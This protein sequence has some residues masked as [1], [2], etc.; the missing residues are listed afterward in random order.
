MDSNQNEVNS[1]NDD[2]SNSNLKKPKNNIV[3]KKSLDFSNALSVDL[4]KIK[5]KSKNNLII[6]ELENNFDSHNDLMNNKK[7]INN[8]LKSPNKEEAKLLSPKFLQI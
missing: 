5:N 3:N 8:F 6:H 1:Y 2:Q 7:D 4:V